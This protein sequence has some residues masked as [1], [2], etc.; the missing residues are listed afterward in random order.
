MDIDDPIPPTQALNRELNTLTPQMVFTDAALLR[1]TL[2]DESK[3]VGDAL[4]GRGTNDA[5]R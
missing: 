5:K 3:D 2:P 1:S 4:H